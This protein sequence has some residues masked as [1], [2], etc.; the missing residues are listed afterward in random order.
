MGKN[1]VLEK[2]K[3]KGKDETNIITHHNILFYTSFLALVSIFYSYHKKLHSCFF[4]NCVVFVTSICNYIKYNLTNNSRYVDIVIVVFAMIYHCKLA[5]TI[6]YYPYII[7]IIIIIIL[8]QLHIYYIDNKKYKVARN[9]WMFVHFYA[10]LNNVF[11]Y[12]QI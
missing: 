8:H 2:N 6:K 1:V 11:L 5:Y 9:V 7:N 4:I 12:N 3:I 10:T